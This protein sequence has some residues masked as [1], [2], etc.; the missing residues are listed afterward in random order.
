M[1]AE[2]EVLNRARQFASALDAE[3]YEAVR[4]LLAPTCRY[5]ART[6]TLT[7]PDSIVESYRTNG[8]SARRL[9]D[10]VQYGSEVRPAGGASVRV[11][12]AD[13]LRK[14][15]QTH[16]YRSQQT[17]RFDAQGLIAEITHEE[18]PLE[19]ERLLAFCARCGVSL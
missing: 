4:A 10:D 18:L 5:Q 19:R 13:Q 1:S 16:V 2:A 9:F 7:G 14:G 12:F 11:V 17:L 6:H 3:R 15:G 8:Q